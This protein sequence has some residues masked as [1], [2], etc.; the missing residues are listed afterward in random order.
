MNQPHSASENVSK[1]MLATEPIP[2][3][4]TVFVWAKTKAFAPAPANIAAKAIAASKVIGVRF[5][6][7]PI[8]RQTVQHQ[9]HFLKI[10]IAQ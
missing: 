7:K 8:L 1:A 3:R 4:I 5:I 9:K 6:T 2:M 10:A